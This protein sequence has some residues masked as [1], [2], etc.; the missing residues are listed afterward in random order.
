M[1]ILES[2]LI[3]EK[4]RKIS[5]IESQIRDEA[6]QRARE[7]ITHAIQRCAADQVTESTVSVVPLPNDEMKGVLSGAKAATSEQSKR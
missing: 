1:S 5:E 3:H 4:A 7:L 2:E 6:D